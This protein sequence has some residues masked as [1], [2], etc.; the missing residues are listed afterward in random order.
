MSVAAVRAIVLAAGASTRMKTKLSKLEQGLLGRPLM[1]WALDQASFLARDITVVVGHRRE[2]MQ[3]LATAHR[4]EGATLSFAWQKEPKGTADAVKAAL[5]HLKDHETVFIMGADTALL[6]SETAKRWHKDFVESKA[7]LSFLTFDT[8]RPHA[9]GRVRRDPQGQPERIVEAKDCER[10]DLSL[11]EVNAGF[12]L[13]RDDILKEGIGS[14]QPTNKAKEFYLTDLVTFCRSK[15]LLVRAYRI[16]EEEALGANTLEEIAALEH[17]LKMRINRYWMKEGVRLIEPETIR[18]DA[19]VD[20]SAN[21]VIHPYVHLRGSTVVGEHAEIGPFCVIKDSSIGDG[22]H[23]ESHCVLD[24]AIVGAK[25]SV[26]PFARLRPGTELEESVHVGNFVEIKKSKLRKGVKAGHLSY[27]GDSDIGEDSNI[28][29]G[30]ITC[31]FDGL[32]KHKT[33]LEKNV[34]IGSNSSLVAPVTIGE[35]AIIGAGSVI[36]ENVG[37]ESLA[38][39]RNAQQ[40]VKEGAKRFRD[41]RKS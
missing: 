16:S 29:A 9:Y 37:A 19:S 12:Y 34:F 17:C 32:H 35:A 41:K 33:V 39:T 6:E 15:D 38:L 13:V 3:A 18:I 1:A 22:A 28:G 26:G 31:N 36:T 10:D 11:T 14:I 21:T 4:P 5:S 2:E 40:E 24:S 30:T 8:S 25:A 20:V 7:A 27:L 23:I